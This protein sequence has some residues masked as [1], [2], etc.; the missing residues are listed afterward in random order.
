M[1]KSLLAVVRGVGQAR[2]QQAVEVALLGRTQGG[3]GE[4]QA[5]E[6]QTGQA[7]G[8]GYLMLSRPFIAAM[9]RTPAP[10]GITT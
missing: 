5:G 6:E 7:H 8:G 9:V 1:P 2:A 3:R 4:Q 10:L